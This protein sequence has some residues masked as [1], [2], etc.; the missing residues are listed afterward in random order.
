VSE[1]AKGVLITGLGV[2]CI[3]PDTL[4]IRL[5]DLDI[6]TLA[7]WRGS[8]QAVGVSLLLAAY[9]RGRTLAV[10]RGI[11]AIG[12]ALAFGFAVATLCFL[13]AILN[14]KVANALVLVSTAP[15]FAAVL[16]RLFLKEAVRPRT[17]ATI[18]V[19][20]AGVA[21]IAGEGIGAGT[22]FGDGMALLCALLAGAK[23]TVIRGRRSVNMAPAMALS[24]LIV[25]LAA[26]PFASLAAPT[27]TQGLWLLLMGFGV[28][29]PATALLAIGPR[30]LP[31]PE[32]A[33]MMLGET[34]LGPLWVWLALS[35][36]PS[37]LGLAG[38]A[39]VL[40]ALAGNT[41]IGLRRRRR[42]ALAPL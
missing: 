5:V 10:F 37:A 30:Y 38:G 19:A 21:L 33:L 24:G 40:V 11:G 18:A 13:A 27:S 12:V 31:A 16:S 17:W 32:A 35:E 20:L 14:T 39:I 1:H 3:S 9:Y 36:A 7:L 26:L 34:V 22:W 15:F 8:F 29:A 23:L 25:A 6:W 42:P 2:L 28:I 4:L 41:L